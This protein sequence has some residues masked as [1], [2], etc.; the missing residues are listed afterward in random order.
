LYRLIVL[1]A[2]L[3]LVAATG[4]SAAAQSPESSRT[5]KAWRLDCFAPKARATDGPDAFDTRPPAGS[6]CQMQQEIRL[7]GGQDKVAAIARV[8]LFGPSRQPFLLLVLPPNA[9]ADL[10][11]SYAVDDGAPLKVR[12]RE[13]T[14]RNC[15]AALQLDADLLDALRRGSRLAV[16]F[17]VGATSLA[18]LV[19]LDGFAAAYAGLEATGPAPAAN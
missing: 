12:I 14:A 7:Q 9:E 3:T 6:N 13:C 1:L 19:A 5:F 17:K 2:C 15:V 4:A 16:G 11:V 18:T 8:R 10:G